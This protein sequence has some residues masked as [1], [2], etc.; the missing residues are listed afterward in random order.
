LCLL[1]QRQP[2][3]SLVQQP[4]DDQ[5]RYDRQVPAHLVAA[6]ANLMGMVRIDP[7]RRQDVGQQVGQACHGIPR[8][9]K[10]G[11]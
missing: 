9:G 2:L 10:V 8:Q 7:W 3:W 4:G 11:L 5:P 1:I 6:V